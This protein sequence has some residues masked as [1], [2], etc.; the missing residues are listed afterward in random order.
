MG[1]STLVK[2]DPMNSK[3][4]T[5]WRNLHSSEPHDIC[6]HTQFDKSCSRILQRNSL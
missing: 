1:F 3:R 2:D 4:V 6:H 5:F